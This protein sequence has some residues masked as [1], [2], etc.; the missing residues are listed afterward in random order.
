MSLYM[1]R[2]TTHVPR[3][4]PESITIFKALIESIVEGEWKIRNKNSSAVKVLQQCN[5]LTN[6]CVCIP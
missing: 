4:W 3:T 6:E 2:K 1:W 5:I